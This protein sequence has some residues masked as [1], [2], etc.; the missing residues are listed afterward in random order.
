MWEKYYLEANAVVFVVDSVDVGRLDEAKI[1]FG[2]WKSS[3]S[4]RTL[5]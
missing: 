5:S 2:E 1:T 4:L 3:C